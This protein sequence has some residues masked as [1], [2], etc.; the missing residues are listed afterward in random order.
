MAGTAGGS[1]RRAACMAMVL[2]VTLSTINSLDV[3]RAGT[4]SALTTRSGLVVEVEKVWDSP[5]AMLFGLV[6]FGGEL[7]VGGMWSGDIY[8]ST[9]QGS[10]WEV[11]FSSAGEGV[12]APSVLGGYLYFST[13]DAPY[14]YRTQDGAQWTEAF[15]ASDVGGFW[16]SA[17]FDGTVFYGGVNPSRIY[18]SPDG[19]DFTKV[20]DQPYDGVYD[21]L[22]AEDRLYIAVMDGES[23]VRFYSTDDG[24]DWQYLSTLSEVRSDGG[25][26]VAFNGEY[27][28]ASTAGNVY[29]TKDFVSFQQVYDGNQCWCMATYGGLLF[30]GHSDNNADADGDAN[31]YVTADG[32]GWELAYDSPEMKSC[33]FGYYSVDDSLYLTGGS[34]WNGAFGTVYRLTVSVGMP[35]VDASVLR[36][37]VQVSDANPAVGE[38][39]TI[40]VPVAVEGGGPAPEPVRL[41]ANDS[42]EEKW[43]VF[44]PDGRWIAYTSDADG[45]GGIWLMAPDGSGHH[46]VI[47][48]VSRLGQS[49]LMGHDWTPDG[50]TLYFAPGDAPS[51]DVYRM[52]IDGTNL[53]FV[54]DG[55]IRDRN[56]IVTPD[57]SYLCFITDPN[58]IASDYV[59]RCGLDGSDPV[60]IDAD[61]GRGNGFLSSSP[62]GGTLYYNYDEGP[63]GYAGPSTVYSLS[64]DGSSKQKVFERSGTEQF[65][66]AKVSPDGDRIVYS[67][68]SDMASDDWDIWVA[69]VDGTNRTPLTAHGANDKQPDWSPD[70]RMVAFTS[71]RGGSNDIWLLELDGDTVANVSVAFYD[72]DP[73]T[74]GT[75]I[76]NVT[77]S[78]WT[79]GTAIAEVVWTPMAPGTR[80][81]HIVAEPMGAT[82]PDQADN[83]HAI[84]F[85][86][87]PRAR[88][89]SQLQATPGVDAG[90]T[91]AIEL[92]VAFEP[93]ARC[94]ITAQLLDADL[95][96]LPTHIEERSVGA[97]GT[98][99][100]TVE[101]WIPPSCPRGIW[102]VQVNLLERLPRDGG[103]SL[104]CRE[105]SVVVR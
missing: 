97:T 56:P 36:A 3:D 39:V 82:D 10:G 20:F 87:A 19:V 92:V 63:S 77:L 94:I 34:H 58:W 62:D 4:A 21:M 76:D 95:T 25:S 27:Y 41:T 6:E 102:T 9:D 57:G 78:E 31:I 1:V 46:E 71:D 90:S 67:Y 73:A 30:A 66:E 99:S 89:I 7:Y 83:R 28:F 84:A 75:L 103:W 105:A 24:K 37:S 70:G 13:H 52:D 98:V 17:V 96:P 81:V 64:I 18:S 45:T 38:Q 86:V 23:S 61:D 43:P 72:G 49:G 40:R 35:A 91:W 101:V 85:D 54:I 33:S 12:R 22:A 93:L 26:L 44:S 50:R 42:S 8:R 65:V 2:M 53:T 51:F 11:C 69:D 68:Q 88:R 79:D 14:I 16:D 55:N 100:L 32:D 15:H 59:V 48:P 60:V 74:G 5:T 80:Q 29:R 104:D 47:D